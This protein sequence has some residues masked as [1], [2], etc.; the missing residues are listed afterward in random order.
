MSSLKK[1]NSTDSLKETPNQPNN[2][3]SLYV[4]AD[5]CT[6]SDLK[7]QMMCDRIVVELRDQCH[8]ESGVT[9]WVSPNMVCLRGQYSLVNTVPP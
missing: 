2:S 9:V 7:D 8:R 3:L 1:S 4:L 5:D 6:Y